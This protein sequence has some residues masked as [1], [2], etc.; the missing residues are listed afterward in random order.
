MEYL[1]QTLTGS[2]L[3]NLSSPHPL[4]GASIPLNFHHVSKSECDR[5]FARNTENVG[6]MDSA[7]YRNILECVK[8]P[9]LCGR[10]FQKRKA[11][12]AEVLQNQK[13]IAWL[14]IEA[15]WR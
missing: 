12:F 8:K 13:Q 3:L 5:I 1:L 11:N 4:Y 14:N 6:K 2:E 10:F 7:K 9:E 15:N